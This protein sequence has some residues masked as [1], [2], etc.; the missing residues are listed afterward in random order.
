[1]FAS[2]LCVLSPSSA[3]TNE[4][5]QPVIL[6]INPSREIEERR[7]AAL[8]IHRG[9]GAFAEVEAPQT[10]DHDRL[11]PEP[12]ELPERLAAGQIEGIDMPVAE[13]AH[14]Q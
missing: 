12:E 11:V 7:S 8:A 3:V 5:E 1:M 2:A 10:L 9:T 6:V 14:H 13:I 4:P